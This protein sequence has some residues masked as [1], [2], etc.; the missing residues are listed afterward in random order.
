MKALVRLD[1]V[2]AHLQFL[3]LFVANKEE[4]TKV[5]LDFS[6]NSNFQ[7]DLS[8]IKDLLKLKFLEA[9]EDYMEIN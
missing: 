7:T 1:R 8:L 3:I 4:N 9:T 2:R 6:L 5:D